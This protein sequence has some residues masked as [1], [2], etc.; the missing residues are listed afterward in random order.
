MSW[1]YLNYPCSEFRIDHLVGN[2]FHFK[3]S[4]QPLHFN[5]L[6]NPFLV[7]FIF[8]V[9]GHRRVSKFCFWSHCSQNKW[10][11]LHV[12]QTIDPFLVINFQLRQRSAAVGAIIHHILIP[13]NF[14]FSLHLPEGFKHLV[15]NIF[16]Q[17]KNV[18]LP[19]G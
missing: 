2:H 12:V 17:C 10:T 16:I 9:H 4:D 6:A 18:P 1:G 7:S 14:S 15:R 5:F 8:R 13:V 19:V 3:F 11:I